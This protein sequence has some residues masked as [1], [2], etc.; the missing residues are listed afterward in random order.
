MKR[1]WSDPVRAVHVETHIGESDIPGAFCFEALNKGLFYICPC[2]CGTLGF[3]RFREGEPSDGPSW[4]FNGNLE[5]PTLSPSIRHLTGC[6]YHGHLRDGVWT[7]EGDSG[8]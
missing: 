2:G 1:Q 5:A 3:L 4:E 8:A 6:H 7:F